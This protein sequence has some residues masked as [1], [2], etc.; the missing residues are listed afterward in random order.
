MSVGF[1]FLILASVRGKLQSKDLRLK[2]A[3]WV[4]PYLGGLVLISYLGSFGGE[5]IIPFG[6]DFLVI[7]VF[8]LVILILA[9]KSR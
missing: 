5:K 6:W 7:S 1:V 2:S 8:I 4:L 9:M 3:L